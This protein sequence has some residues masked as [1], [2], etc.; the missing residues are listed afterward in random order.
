MKK[1][2]RHAVKAAAVAAVAAVWI[3][4]NVGNEVVSVFRFMAIKLVPWINT[5]LWA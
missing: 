3:H 5:V 2:F 1:I 4:F